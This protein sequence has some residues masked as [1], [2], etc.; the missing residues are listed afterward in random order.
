VREGRIRPK[1]RKNHEKPDF[2]SS[3]GSGGGGGLAAK[4]A[5]EGQTLLIAK[6][7]STRD[8]SIV[9]KWSCIT[10]DSKRYIDRKTDNVFRLRI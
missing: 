2:S 1:T 9:P 5:K 8:Q 3:S 10:N 4:R 7:Y 6:T